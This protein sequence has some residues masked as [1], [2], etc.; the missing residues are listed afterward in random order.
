[1]YYV[2]ATDNPQI[3]AIVEV[4][5]GIRKSTITLRG[6]ELDGSPIVSGDRCSFVVKLPNNVRRG[7]IF[8]V[9]SGTFIT[10]FR[11]G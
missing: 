5:T 6:G 4:N 7:M 2:T 9:P 10:D 3:L 8:K 11:V 1:M